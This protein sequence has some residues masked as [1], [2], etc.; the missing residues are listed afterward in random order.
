[1]ARLTNEEM[2]SKLSS[3]GLK[4]R[5]KPYNDVRNPELPSGEEKILLECR[6]PITRALDGVASGT[7]IDIY[8]SNTVRVLTPRKTKAMATARA[9]GFK[10]RLLDGEA[11]LYLPMSRADEFLHGFGAK[12]KATRNLTPEQ[13]AAAVG[14]LAKG[15]QDRKPRLAVAP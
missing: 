15:R 9:N 13:R 8:D 5:Y 1:M 7:E 6:R 10:V 2:V 4:R 12:V 3:L 11:E 14:R